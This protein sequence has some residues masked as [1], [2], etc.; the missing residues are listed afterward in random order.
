MKLTTE[1]LFVLCSMPDSTDTVLYLHDKNSN[2]RAFYLHPFDTNKLSSTYIHTDSPILNPDIEFHTTNN[3]HLKGTVKENYLSQADEL[4]KNIAS[5]H[6]DKIIL[7]RLKIEEISNCDYTYLFN[8]IAHKYPNAFC[9]FFNIPGQGSWMGASPELLLENNTDGFKTVALAG[10]KPVH[11]EIDNEPIWGNKELNEQQI[12]VDYLSEKLT[13]LNL[14]F[15][16]NGPNTVRAGKV[17]HL[18]TNFTSHEHID[19]LTLALSLHPGPAIS[20]YPVSKAIDFIKKI[21]GHDREYYCGFM[22]PCSEESTQ[23]FVNLRCM[24]I[25]SDALCLYAGGGYTIDSIPEDEWQETE[26]KCETLLSVLE[27]I[28]ITTNDIE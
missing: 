23:F 14:K 19:P 4:I 7:S 9:F 8:A 1:D 27:D 16:A 3:C 6:C 17:Y 20:G 15:E 12:I 18:K 22:G 21:E 26:L 25:F 24:Q 2:N 5:N 10:T 11:N 28:Y 13:G